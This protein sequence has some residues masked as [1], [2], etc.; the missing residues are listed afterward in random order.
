MQL[1]GNEMN[2]QSLGQYLHGP[3]DLRLQS[4]LL[5]SPEEHEVQVAIRSTTLCGSDLHYYRHFRNGTIEVQEPLCLGHESAGEI[6]RLG[7][8]AKQLNPS[9]AIGD[10]VA[11]E[12]GVPCGDCGLC[13]KGRYN[14]CPNLRFRSS[15]SKFPRYQDTLQEHLNHPAQWVHKLPDSLNHE[16]GALLE[17]LAVSVH[18][19]RR[20]EPPAAPANWNCLIFGAGAVGLLCAAAARAEGCSD[21]VLADIDPGRLEFALKHGF[22][23]AIYLVPRQKPISLDE[24]K[25]IAKEIQH[26][27]LPAGDKFGHAHAVLECTG[28]ESCLQTSIYVSIL[29]PCRPAR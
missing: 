9:L 16:I 24:N 2:T 14:I 8:G 4:H 17:P 29:S 20:I 28:V 15:G 26:I 13:E 6:V 7:N 5:P 19:V 25:R 12:V 22:A 11:L 27:V 10:R 18:A 1:Q 3:N 23:S 21:V